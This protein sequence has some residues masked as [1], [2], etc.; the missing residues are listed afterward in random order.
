M[1]SRVPGVAIAGALGGA[2]LCSQRSVTLRLAAAQQLR[3]LFLGPEQLS[4]V[5]A[6]LAAAGTHLDLVVVDEAHLLGV[7]GVR[8][9]LAFTL[10]L[11]TD[12]N[13]NPN[14]TPNSSFST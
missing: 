7:W 11:T 2:D 12:R 5:L 9:T 13:S 1:A 4:T 10:V 8:L 14:P 6:V 3:L